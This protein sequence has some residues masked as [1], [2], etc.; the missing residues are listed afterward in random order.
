MKLEK[1]KILKT[2]GSL[3]H[4]QF[5]RIQ[6]YEIGRCNFQIE[7][8]TV[9]SKMLRSSSKPAIQFEK[10]YSSWKGKKNYKKRFICVSNRYEYTIIALGFSLTTKIVPNK[11][12]PF[13]LFFFRVWFFCFLV[14]FYAKCIGKGLN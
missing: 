6:M 7:K 4:L 10:D 9:S 5:S 2:W 11:I 1:T 13:S 14:F 8:V 3:G 12:V